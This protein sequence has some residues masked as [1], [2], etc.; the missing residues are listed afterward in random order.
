MNILSESCNNSRNDTINNSNITSNNSKD[1]ISNIDINL[2]NLSRSPVKSP[3]NKVFLDFSDSSSTDFF[4]MEHN[5]TFRPIKEEDQDRQQQHQQLQQQIDNSVF[6]SYIT[7]PPTDADFSNL[8]SSN[9]LSRSR[10]KSAP[11]QK[12]HQAQQKAKKPSR[13]PSTNSDYE[14]RIAAGIELVNSGTI[15]IRA[16][17]KKVQVSHETLR[18]RHQGASSRHEFHTQLMAL[19]PAEEQLIENMLLRFPA[20]SNLLTSTF[21][22][23][24]VNDYRRQKFIG[25]GEPVPVGF[26]DLGISWTSGFRRRHELVGEIM[27]KSMNR[28]PKAPG[29]LDTWYTDVATGFQKHGITPENVF[30]LVELGYY[31][32]SISSSTTSRKQTELH[33][34]K[35][36]EFITLN[37][38][39][40]SSVLGGVGTSAAASGE[41]SNNLLM[42]SLEAIT[43]TGS[44]LP[45]M[46]IVKGDT[47]LVSDATPEYGS[48]TCTPDTRANSTAFLDWLEYVFDTHT[49]P[50]TTTLGS[51]TRAIFMEPNPGLFSAQVLQFALDHDIVF[52]LFPPPVPI[53]QT[54]FSPTVAGDMSAMAQQPIDV[55]LP[56]YKELVRE[57]TSG[58]ITSASNGDR[59][60]PSNDNDNDEESENGSER[61]ISDDE[62]IDW[63]A[64]FKALRDAR[65]ETLANHD[66]WQRTG[67]ILPDTVSLSMVLQSEAPNTTTTMTVPTSSTTTTTTTTTTATSTPLS[68]ENSRLDRIQSML[69]RTASLHQNMQGLGTHYKQAMERY[70]ASRPSLFYA[71]GSPA[72]DEEARALGVFMA[73]CWEAIDQGLAVLMEENRRSRVII[74][75]LCSGS[76]SSGN[77][78]RSN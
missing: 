18:R 73:G 49:A 24:L 15:S 46:I 68:M 2:I 43:G 16:A 70:L 61:I 62:T 64:C 55:L 38:S 51:A 48:L 52:F 32:H 12:Q 28:D 33:C 10:S 63:D 36:S 31:K 40:I 69:H 11:A 60:S 39:S 19:S 22:C 29:L 9:H 6:D 26:K 7:T 8:P 53:V 14:L 50:A 13:K 20:F 74:D 5:Y 57:M 45:N 56:R 1:Y 54:G 25:N 77:S 78:S 59:T 41:R 30:N 44:V 21:L 42:T 72:N 67:I 71:G 37:S 66:A 4:L 27:A 75:E 23:N 65:N 3:L 76:N 58:T 34:Y 35:R 17:A 47:S